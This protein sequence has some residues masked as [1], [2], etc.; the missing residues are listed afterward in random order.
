VAKTKYERVR[1]YPLGDDPV[2]IGVRDSEGG[3][4]LLTV[5]RAGYR[6]RDE[7]EFLQLL[8]YVSLE[9]LG[10]RWAD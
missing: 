8:G 7:T 9:L 2:Q 10:I 3:E 6:P 1:F 5:Q 4:R